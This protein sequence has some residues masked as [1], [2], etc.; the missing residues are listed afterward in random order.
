MNAQRFEQI[1]EHFWQALDRDLSARAGFFS[2]LRA[3]DADLADEVE[4]LVDADANAEGFLAGLP[5]DV[6]AALERLKRVVADTDT[7][8]LALQGRYRIE[9]ELGQGGMSTVYLATDFRHD[10]RIALKVVRPDIRGSLA[11]ERFQREIRIAGQLQ[12]PHIL[13]IFDSGEAAGF[14]YYVMPYVEGET[15]DSR[16]K[17]EGQLP[18]DD[19]LRITREVAEALEYAHGRGVVHRDI[20]PGNILLSGDHAS[21][22]DFGIARAMTAAGTDS[23]TETGVA[24]GTPS[25]M[26]PE[27][28][29]GHEL[30]GRSDIYSLGCVLYEMLAGSPPFIG[31]NAQVA[32]ARHAVDTAPPLRT[33][34]PAVPAGTAAVIE[35]ALAKT[36]A[37][38]WRSAA[39]FAAA[40]ERS[41]TARPRRAL[42]RWRRYLLPAALGLT[43]AAAGAMALVN[44]RGSAPPATP[45]FFQLTFTGDVSEAAISPDGKLVA[46]VTSPRQGPF[47]NVKTQRILLKQVAGDHTHIVADSLSDVCGLQFMSGGDRLTFATRGSGR[48]ER[49]VYSVS[50]LGGTPTPIML[51][52]SPPCSPVLSPDRSKA[53]WTS[54]NPAGDL[55]MV[56]ELFGGSG[57]RDSILLGARDVAGSTIWSHG[58][59]WVLAETGDQSGSYSLELISPDDGLLHAVVTGDRSLRSPRWS[60]DDGAIY[61]AVGSLNAANLMKVRIDARTGHVV[62]QPELLLA[63]IPLKTFDIAMDG[64]VLAM[65]R[66]TQRGRIWVGSIPDEAT[67]EPAALV[68]LSEGAVN[69]WEP[70]ISPDGSTVAFTRGEVDGRDIFVRTIGGGTAQRIAAIGSHTYD[71]RWSPDGQQLAFVWDSAGTQWIAVASVTSRR[72]RRLHKSFIGP[73]G[74]PSLLDWAPA[75]IIFL[76]FAT[77]TSVALHL[78]DPDVG[79]V[80]RL[81]MAAGPECAGPPLTSPDGSRVLSA[82][83]GCRIILSLPHG[84]RLGSLEFTGWPIGWATN[85]RIYYHTVSDNSS[86]IWSI[87]SE[88]GAPEFHLRLDAR[89]ASVTVSRNART[90]ACQTFHTESDVWLVKGFDRTLR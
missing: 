54:F 58:G 48:L 65:T 12:H 6:P 87:S 10:R 56:R 7:L 42:T 14:L 30:D 89:C 33:A 86:E 13:P 70:A 40:L 1:Q 64:S 27:Q 36:P 90:F 88:G 68:E 25:Y 82:R 15:L 18:V 20:K 9:R 44:V 11:A 43:G 51:E 72:W 21:I 81:P 49:G 66:S 71:V 60:P 61:Y 5:G 62:G 83:P 67:D 29:F 63:G 45:Q 17:R 75:G 3:R 78:L 55:V 79:R 46:Y 22:A 35:K 24:V 26:S 41:T 31:P 39:E 52:D 37:D 69:D 19:A 57:Q 2:E 4:S 85:G 23:V 8:Q 47:T 38:R 84:E 34:R 53:V 74:S 59:R 73:D 16:L 80:Q 50:W 28:G 76:G 77:D 32:L